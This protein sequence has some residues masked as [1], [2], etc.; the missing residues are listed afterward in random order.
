[1][2]PKVLCRDHLDYW[3]LC[4]ICHQRLVIV[5]RT[6]SNDVA[7]QRSN[8]IWQ[9]L[10]QNFYHNVLMLLS[11]EDDAAPEKS[12]YTRASSSIVFQCESAL[13]LSPVR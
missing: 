9:E 5:F 7:N 8:P 4:P 13:D 3:G 1:M 6:L 10:R 12:V 2:R 11:D